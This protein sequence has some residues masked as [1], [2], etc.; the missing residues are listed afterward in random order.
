MADPFIAECVARRGMIH[1]G[2]GAFSMGSDHFYPEERPVRRVAVDRF[3]IDRYA[4]T[5][6]EFAR[7]VDASGWVTEAEKAPDPS[8][9]P[10]APPE[11]LVPGSLVFRQTDGPVDLDDYSQ[12]WAWTPGADWRHP[13]GPD[14]SVARLGDHPAVHLNYEDA[15][16]YCAWAGTSLPTEAEWEFA[17]RGGLK[18]K[19]FTWGDEDTQ[20]THPMANTWQGRF[21]WENTQV[22]GWVRTAPVGSFEPNGYGLHDMAGNVWEWTDD[23][24][25]ASHAHPDAPSCCVPMNPR[26]GSK[27]TSLDPAQPHTPIPRKVLKGGSYLCAPSYCLRYRPAARQPQMID[28]GMSHLG[29]RTVVRPTA[30]DGN[31][32]PR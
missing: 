8:L 11:L 29:F 27:E 9:Y 26:G 28:T 22:D 5:N 17:A 15:S 3:W 14:S 30:T 4:V 7:F 24:Y 12:W 20:D 13:L 1:I 21:P 25:R 2:E 10:G 6:K 18:G 32:L 31:S 19:D 23:W 16:A